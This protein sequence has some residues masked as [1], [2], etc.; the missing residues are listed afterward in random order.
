MGRRRALSESQV[1]HA[2]IAYRDGMSITELAKQFGVSTTPVRR[3]LLE[4]G[5]ELRGR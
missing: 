1:Q 2:V 3:A 4:A 5:V